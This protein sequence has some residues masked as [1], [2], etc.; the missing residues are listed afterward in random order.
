MPRNMLMCKP[1]I[2]LFC[3]LTIQKMTN[4]ITNGGGTV[5]RHEKESGF[6][7]VYFVSHFLKIGN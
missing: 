3:H 4:E 1:C 5:A 7:D 6:Y 2:V